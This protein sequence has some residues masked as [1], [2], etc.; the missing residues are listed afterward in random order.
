MIWGELSGSIVLKAG[1]AANSKEKGERENGKH[2]RVCLFN[3][4]RVG[5][6]LPLETKGGVTKD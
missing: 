2:L 5:V 3:L 6:W 4:W 1:L